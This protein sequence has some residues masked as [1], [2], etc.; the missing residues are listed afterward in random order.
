MTH[1]KWDICGVEWDFMTAHLL[2]GWN[3]FK[4]SPKQIRRA[5]AHIVLNSVNFFHHLHVSLYI[6]NKNVI[7]I[8]IVVLLFFP[9]EDGVYNVVLY[10]VLTYR[11]VAIVLVWNDVNTSVVRARQIYYYIYNS[12][13]NSHMVRLPGSSQIFRP[14]QFLTNNG[15]C[16]KV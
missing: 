10:M 14:L 12:R 2:T 15:A 16:P 6:W 13:I 9:T 3:Q 4:V 7:L 1:Y 8:F 5:L 11:T